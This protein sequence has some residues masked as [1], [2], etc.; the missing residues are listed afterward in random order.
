MKVKIAFLTGILILLLGGLFF[1][2][3]YG[4]I[5]APDIQCSSSH[6][7]TVIPPLH[8]I[9]GKDYFELGNY[10]YDIGDCKESIA[11]YTRSLEIDPTYPQ[12]WNNRGYTYMR[13]REYD[14]ALPDLDKAISLKPNYVQA[15]INRGDIHNYYYHIDRKAAVN[16]YNKVIALGATEDKT[17][18]GHKAMAETNNMVPL[19]FL[20]MFTRSL[21]K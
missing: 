7:S 11:D 16:D 6:S 1:I 18:C 12:A 10:H 21:C 15:L 14:K 5:H 4:L 8:P 19:A 20:H 17:V 2:K 13:L 9:T 3:A